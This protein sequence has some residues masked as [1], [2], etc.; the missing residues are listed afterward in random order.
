MKY[1]PYH[2]HLDLALRHRGE[3]PGGVPRAHLEGHP[4]LRQ[5]KVQHRARCLA[6]LPGV[7]GAG[8]SHAHVPDQ[9]LLQLARCD[10]AR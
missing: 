6:R 4:T 3:V 7:E 1:T 5:A 2:M 8:G 10:R 9:L